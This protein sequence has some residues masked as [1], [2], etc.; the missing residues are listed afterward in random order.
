MC[1]NSI[2]KKTVNKTNIT[3]EEAVKAAINVPELSE[4]K[5]ILGDIE[6]KVIDLGYDDYLK[7]L[8]FLTPML[9]AFVG[10]LAS[11]GG[12]RVMT[13]AAE[14]N[15]TAIIKYC[16]ESLPELACLV[17]NQTDPSITKEDVKKWSVQGSPKGPFKLA[18]IVLK[19]I[20]QNKIIA[21]FA[22]FFGQMLPMIQA[23]LNLKR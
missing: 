9:E 12:V 14:V 8:T 11:I 13:P 16:G 5:F 15:A 18:E 3:N 7:F 22:S 6:F 20:D 21:D 17:C 1:Y 19:Q 2:N 10:S 23:A 4:V